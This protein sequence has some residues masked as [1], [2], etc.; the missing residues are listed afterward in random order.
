M[1]VI[2]CLAWYDERADWLAECITSLGPLCRQIVALDGAYS[3]WP[4]GQAHSDSAQANAIRRA[5]RASGMGCTIHEPTQPWPGD[6]VEK[7]STLMAV[8]E[9]V[10]QPGDWLFVVDA[11]EL[12]TIAPDDLRARLSASQ[13]DAGDCTLWMRPAPGNNDGAPYEW[14]PPGAGLRRL[15]RAGLGLRVVGQH[16]NYRSADGRSISGYNEEAGEDFSDLRIEHR[17]E[18]RAPARIAAK[19]RY[20]TERDTLGLE[21]VPRG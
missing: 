14:H 11:D 2:A 21:R 3:T 20:Y 12:L 5:A 7:R 6:E 4:E 15:F 10:A 8:A 9:A 1:N 13:Y 19:H 18:P 16:T 17:D